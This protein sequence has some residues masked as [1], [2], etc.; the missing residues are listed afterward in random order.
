MGYYGLIVQGVFFNWSYPKN[1]KYG[2]KLKYQNWSYPKIH[3]YGKKLKY[4]NWS[5]PKIHKYQNWSPPQKTETRTIVFHSRENPGQQLIRCLPYG[6]PTASSVVVFEAQHGGDQLT[7]R[8]FRGDQFESWKHFTYR[9]TL[10]TFRG[11]QLT[12]RGF[13]GG[14]V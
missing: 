8:N 5:S 11:D 13:R 3:K 7:L 10:R 4:Q 9:K 14:P 6:K 12:L 1:H 2:K